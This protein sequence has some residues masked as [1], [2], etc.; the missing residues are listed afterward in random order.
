MFSHR[1]VQIIVLMSSLVGCGG[2]PPAPAPAPVVTAGSGE[3]LPAIASEPPDEGEASGANVGHD[4]ITECNALIGVINKGV[5]DLNKAASTPPSSSSGTDDYKAMADTMDRVVNDV[6]NLELRDKRL[7]EFSEAYQTM[8]R[9]V[10]KSARTLLAAAKARNM[11]K[12]NAAKADVEKV[13]QQEDPLVDGI[14][15]YCHEK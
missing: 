14:N 1:L 11:A 6:S 7:Q 3:P 2:A 12:V 5:D 8:A 15:K 10:A 13:V 4:K 9:Q